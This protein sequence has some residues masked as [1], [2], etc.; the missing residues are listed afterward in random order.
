[1]VGSDKVT[2]QDVEDNNPPARMSAETPA[3][4]LKDNTD[5]V[6]DA[7][8]FEKQADFVPSP[9]DQIDALGI[10]EWRAL[11][12]KI[13]RRL[14]MTLMPCLWSLYLFNYLD[15]ASI[16]QARLNTFE[17][18]LGL[19]D[20]HFQTAVMILSLGYVL[21]QI[22]SN[23]IIG[24][25][26][27]S[28]Y[29]CLMAIVWS[30][31]SVSMCG[32]TNFTGLV[33]VRFFLGVVEAPLLP[34]AVY[35]MSCWYTRKEM[36]M[37]VA[38]LFTGQ[39]LAYCTAGLIAA[40]VFGTLDQSY[41]IAGWK[42]LFIVLAVCGTGLALI[43]LFLLPD[44]PH[45]QS[46]SAM[47]TMTSDMRRIASARIVA[48]RVSTSAATTGVWAGLKMALFDWK[49]VL[50]VTLNIGISAAYGFS[51]F[52]PS[53]VRGFGYSD[54]VSLLLTCPPY[55]FA[56]LGSL[57]NAWHSDRTGERGYHFAGPIAVGCA[58]YVVCL[59]TLDGGAR[60]GAAFVYVGGMY[61]ANPLISTW[62]S[63]TMGRTPENRAVSV[64]LCNVLGQVGNVIAPYFFRDRDEPRYQLAFILMM[65][66]AAVAVTAALTLKFHMKR[67][68]RRLYEK[69][70]LEGTVYQPYVT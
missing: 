29:L 12:K 11:E 28:L 22:P 51:N 39:T 49:M 50:L 7:E 69:A 3:Q 54:V 65:V 62:V 18:D 23:M 8:V 25:L 10:P 61:T 47:W 35:L 14:D 42:W 30:G 21:G 9:E 32:T 48:D 66:C 57:L 31:V 37:R 34:G 60:Y 70:L 15:R 41:G 20:D 19:E 64:A 36:A 55:I 27:P 13:V 2:P 53:I 58:G 17:E 67:L 59:A 16:A 45:S 63:S 6:A 68:N 5:A 44:Y 33:L 46:G 38:I 40:A 1:M 56:A 52:F 26:R 4:N 24:Y 43:S